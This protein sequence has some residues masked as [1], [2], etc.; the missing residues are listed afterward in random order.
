MANRRRR[1]LSK[2]RL[3]RQKVIRPARPQDIDE[4]IVLLQQLCAIEKDFSFNPERQERGLRLLIESEQCAVMVAEEDGRVIGMG[5]G[6]LVVSTAEGDMALL[7]E[8][9]VVDCLFRRR[10]VGRGLVKAIGGWGYSR[11]AI[12]MQLLADSHNAHGL[13][14]YKSLGWERTNMI[15]LRKYNSQEI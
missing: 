7:I 11:G 10:G 15:C 14:F 2:A 6:Q 4:M 3:S 8:D 9:V 12:R 1:S 5:T 13:M